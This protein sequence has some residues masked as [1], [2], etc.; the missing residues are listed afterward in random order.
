MRKKK[1][2]EEF[3]KEVYDLVKNEYEVLG[4]YIN[5][6]TYI[7]MKH[8]KCGHIYS[9]TP[10]K[11]L[12]GRRCP[13]CFGIKKKTSEGFKKEVYDLVKDE[14]E[15]L[16]KYT[17][18]K[19]KIEI[20]HNKCGH[21]YMVIP[22][23]FLLQDSR[24]PECF[25]THL[26]TTEEFKKEVY[27]LVEDEYEVLDEYVNSYTPINMK[28]NKCEYVYPVRPSSF[29]R[30][31]RCPECFGTHLKTTEQFKKEVYEK[32]GDEFEVLGKYI[33]N[34]TPLEIKHSE[35]GCTYL[36]RP[37][38]FLRRYR[39]PKCSS[40]KGESA[41]IKILEKYNITY[42]HNKPYS[43]CKYKSLLRFDFLIFDNNNLKL[44]C[45]FDGEQHF[46]P[47]EIYKGEDGF[48]ET[49]V[50]DEIKNRYCS[51][52]QIPLLRIPYWEFDNIDVILCRELYKLGLI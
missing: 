42:L 41:I 46:K 50:R 43:G 47:V 29:L 22:S 10:S 15:V 34:K 21:A 35:C 26:K 51:D 3:K 4:E 31:S 36:I 9:V 14:Y 6:N 27:D 33:N 30:G 13:E 20:K 18:N 49:Q 17:G 11:F 7:A 52:N 24:C 44:I 39:C 48:L 38:D 5:A 40:R 45:E 25:G 28:H 12:C 2:T 37:N 1:T 16:G 8:N 19:N 32:V 23:N